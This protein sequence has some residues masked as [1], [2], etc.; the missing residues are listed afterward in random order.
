MAV[1]TTH[2]R[3]A[4]RNEKLAARFYFYSDLMGLRYEVC[5]K[6]LEQ[7]FDVSETRIY[8]LVNENSHQIARLKHQKTNTGELSKRY[9]F[10]NWSYHHAMRFQTSEP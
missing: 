3:K 4:Y 1:T 5:T 7:E 2:K 6:L 10:L 8:E 9:P